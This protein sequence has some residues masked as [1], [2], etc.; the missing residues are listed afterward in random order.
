MTDQSKRQFFVL[1]GIALVA[2]VG[3]G[4]IA[5]FAGTLLG[6]VPEPS[7]TPPPPTDT[8]LPPPV[9]TIQ[10]IKSQAKLATVEYSTITEIYNENVPEGWLDDLLGTK[11][12]LLMLV[13]GDVQAG[14]D[15]EKLEEKNLWT[16][17]TRVR[18][19]LP[20]PEILN[21]SI[22]FDRTHIVYYENN[23]ILDDNNPNL[24]GEALAQ[25]QEAVEKA[26]LEAGILNQANDYAQLYYERFLYSLG[27]TEVEVVVDAQL[28]KE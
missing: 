16:D 26:A 21:T 11:E 28:F 25:A 17:G 3:V 23:L 20:A 18:L 2:L 13:Y 8:P 10:G 9:I 27:F 14:F 5:F 4:L 12:R 1:A 24:Q 6:E 19:V 22:D 7:P 15:L